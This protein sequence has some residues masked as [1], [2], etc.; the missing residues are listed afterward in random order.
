[1]FGQLYAAPLLL[2]NAGKTA[3][4]AQVLPR[5]EVDAWITFNPDFG[6]IQVVACSCMRSNVHMLLVLP[7]LQLPDMY[8]NGVAGQFS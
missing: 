5:P 6:F 8:M 3:L 1:M 4:K 2:A 7:C